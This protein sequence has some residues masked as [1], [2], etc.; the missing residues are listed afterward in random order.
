MLSRWRGPDHRG[1]VAYIQPIELKKSEGTAQQMDERILAMVLLGGMALAV[2]PA[3]YGQAEQLTGSEVAAN[4]AAPSADLAGQLPAPNPKSTVFGGEIRSVD[5]VRDELTLRTAGMRPMKILFD[6]RTQ[7][8]VD[9][10]KMSLRDLRPTD[11][12]SVQTALDGTDIFAVSI[13]ILSHSPEGDYQ[14][15]VLRYDQDTRKLT[16]S[17]PQS[18]EPFTI[19]VPQGASFSRIGQPAFAATQSGPTDLA[20]GALVSV[21]FEA[22]NAGQ[23]V[24]KQITILAVPGAAFIFSGTI[25]MLDLAAGSMTLVNPRD[26]RSYQVFFEPRLFPE[27]RNLH[28]GSQV[29]VTAAYNGVRYQVTKLTMQ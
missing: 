11:H 13:H 26:N 21:K 22:G 25:S 14:G 29:Y 18:R 1:R 5:P 17:A 28:V 10:K 2:V 12:A 9:G 23:G 16:V 4:T 27:S 15:R 7:F 8:Y 3:A 20:P 6:E 19:F 24:A